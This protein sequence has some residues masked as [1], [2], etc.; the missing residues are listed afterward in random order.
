[1]AWNNRGSIM[2]PPGP[3]GADGPQGPK[4]DTG[5]TGPQ[6]PAGVMSDDQKLALFGSTSYTRKPHGSLVWSGPWYNPPANAFTRL[7]AGGTERMVV[8]RNQNGCAFAPTGGDAYLYA[9]V[10]GIYNLSAA[11]T[12]GNDQGARGIGLSTST[13]AGDQ[14]VLLWQDFGFGRITVTSRC[15]YL[16]AGTRLYPW[17]WAPTNAGMSPQ[18]R[19]V[20]SEYSI[21]FIGGY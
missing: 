20:V 17:V 10:N 11:Q 5:A 13:A 16:A 19:G 8:A 9:P 7:R 4:G 18:D 2:G 15:L 1:M 3:R 14:G 21:S 6:G 12:W